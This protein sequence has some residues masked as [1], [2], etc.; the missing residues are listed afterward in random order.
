MLKKIKEKILMWMVGICYKELSKAMEERDSS[1]IEYIK[2]SIDEGSAVYIMAHPDMVDNTFGIHA[3]PEE[4][5][6]INP[7]TIVDDE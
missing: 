5:K 7:F 6:D 1:L 3:V 4:E 2:T